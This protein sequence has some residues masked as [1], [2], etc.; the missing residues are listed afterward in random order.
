MGQATSIHWDESHPN[1]KGPWD[2]IH[3]HWDESS[4]SSQRLI[5]A[6]TLHPQGIL[7]KSG[8][9]AKD[10]LSRIPWGS[11]NA[12]AAAS[13]RSGDPAW[14]TP[15]GMVRRI[16]DHGSAIPKSMVR[17]SP[18]HGSAIPKAWFGQSENLQNPYKKRPKK[19]FQTFNFAPCAILHVS[20]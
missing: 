13:T 10:Q 16:R 12:A 15:R 6:C 11:I 20:N 18:K 17:R 9:A 1:G 3:P 8:L 19:H 14:G 2:E 7:D 4:Q 5:K